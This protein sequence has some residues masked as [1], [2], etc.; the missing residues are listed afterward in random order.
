MLKHKR[1]H[2]LDEIFSV[3]ELHEIILQGKCIGPLDLELSEAF[4]ISDESFE[5]DDMQIGKLYLCL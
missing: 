3:Y 1:A 5:I 4:E 2:P